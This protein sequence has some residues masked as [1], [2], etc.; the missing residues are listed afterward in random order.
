MHIRFFVL[1]PP[2]P[3]NALWSVQQAVN[4]CE[5]AS[6]KEKKIGVR[7]GKQEIVGKMGVT[8]KADFILED[9]LRASLNSKKL[10]Q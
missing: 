9:G 7:Y 10:A 2:P 1:F 4:T 5:R 6:H 3:T 8:P